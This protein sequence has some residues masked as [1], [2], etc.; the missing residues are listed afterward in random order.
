LYRINNL[1]TDINMSYT[2]NGESLVFEIANL[3]NTRLKNELVAPRVFQVLNKYLEYKGDSFKHKLY[4]ILKMS[5]DDI[6]VNSMSENLDPLPISIVH[7]ILDLF[8]LE[9]VTKFIKDNKIV[10]VPSVLGNSYDGLREQND[11]GSREQ[12]YLID[13]YYE[14]MALITIIK[15]TL[16]VVGMYVTLKKSSISPSLKDYVILN[17][18]MGDNIYNSKPF[19]KLLAY[20]EKLVGIASQKE[21]FAKRII[22]KNL[23]KDDMGEYV[24]ASAVFQR[25]AYTNEID[26]VEDK[27]AIT[28]LYSFVINNIK[29]K[30]TENSSNIRIKNPVGNGGND[31]NESE[32]EMETNRTPVDI[33]FGFIEEFQYSLEKASVILS[34][35]G[36]NKYKALLAEVYPYFANIPMGNIPDFN[37]NIAF[38]IIKDLI[39]FRASD[40]VDLEKVIN[41]LS[42][43][44]VYCIVNEH[45]DV[46][47]I[48]ASHTLDEVEDVFK[49]HTGHKNK[50]SKE[51]KDIINT[52]FPYV[53]IVTIKDVETEVSYIETVINKTTVEMGKSALISILTSELHNEIFGNTNKVIKINQNIKNLLAELIIDINKK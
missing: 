43:A 29:L 50:I 39:D 8:K 21:D 10:R 14:L 46:A 12:T 4:N 47:N 31:T 37:V 51:N 3:I 48:I 18:Y 23:P 16:P 34:Q 49:Y 45:F 25:L 44:F 13:D 42:V 28:K 15:A 41:V 1:N 30:A 52:L 7:N 26:D 17:F 33:T 6:L 53:N 2:Y 9:D 20:I 40:Y 32:S 27:N 11:Q 38:W 5:Y 19:S 24:L 36:L 22:E 35:L